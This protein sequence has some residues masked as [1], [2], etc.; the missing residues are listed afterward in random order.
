[1]IIPTSYIVEPVC[2]REVDIIPTKDHH[3]RRNGSLF[4]LVNTA[5][6]D[7]LPIELVYLTVCYPRSVKGPHVH[8]PPKTDR[9]VCVEGSCTVYCRNEQTK[10]ISHF[11]LDHKRRKLLVIPSYN[12]HAILSLEGCT[13]LSICTEKYIAGH[14]NQE[15]ITWEG[16]DWDACFEKEE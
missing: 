12:S 6:P 7:S 1:M 4:P 5:D 3:N 2:C 9:F 11:K 10:V 8:F 13:V 14:Y 15:D 16:F